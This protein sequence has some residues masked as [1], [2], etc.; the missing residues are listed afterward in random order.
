MTLARNNL[1]NG[2]KEQGLLELCNNARIYL[3]ERRTLES[4]CPI[5]T[6]L[7]KILRDERSTPTLSL[8]TITATHLDRLLAELLKPENMQVTALYSSVAQKLERKWSLR[9]RQQYF[10]IDQTRYENLPK[11]GLLKDVMFN[12]KATTDD[13]VWKPKKLHVTLASGQT[14]DSQLEVGKLVYNFLPRYILTVAN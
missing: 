14:D 2:R 13:N 7:H 10:D 1:H 4:Q 5:V 6:L 9:F 8:A 12:T 3:R 11:H